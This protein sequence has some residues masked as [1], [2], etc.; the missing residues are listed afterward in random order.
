MPELQLLSQIEFFRGLGKDELERLAK[1]AV[2]LHL[3][4]D[5]PIFSEGSESAAFYV[6]RE[7]AVTIYRDKVGEPMRLLARI[8][9]GDYFGEFGLFED[10]RHTSS[11][12]TSEPTHLIKINNADLLAFLEDHPEIAIRLQMAAA[13]R[14]TV[15]AAAALEL[16]GRSDL[17]I[18]VDQEVPLTF[19]DGSTHVVLLDN[20]S[21]GGLSLRNAPPDWRVGSRTKFD[22]GYGAHQ[23]SCEMRVAWIQGDSVGLAFTEKPVS[24]GER[25]RS[26]LSYFLRR[27]RFAEGKQ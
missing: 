14:H 10:A 13:K 4:A 21:P 18:R 23:L 6:I 11:A 15:N 1:A 12:R 19:E 22:L 16:G 3:P 25:V 26:T 17:R 27:A 5:H 2:E 20:L 8:G 7:G 24:H 9:S